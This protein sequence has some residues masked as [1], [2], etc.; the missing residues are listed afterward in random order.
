M[1]LM[2]KFAI[3]AY[4]TLPAPVVEMTA[5]F[6][7]NADSIFISYKLTGDLNSIDLG[8]GTP[9][10][11][12]VKNLWEKTCFEL[13]I[14]NQKKHYT[15]FNFSPEFEWNAYYFETLRG[16][17]LEIEKMP[18]PK[19]DILL[20]LDVFHLI[21]EIDKRA[22]PE[23]FFKSGESIPLSA[24]ITSVIKEK[25]NQLSYWAL[26]HVDQ[27]PNFHHPDSFKYKF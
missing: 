27:K 6:N 26:S 1:I 19:I 3:T 12:R 18:A 16:P 24:G 9:K 21:A 22:F 17:L 5:E 7:Q 8:T 23:G 15:E 2:P 10:H 25:N 4:P 13:F 11:K 20:S 14:Q